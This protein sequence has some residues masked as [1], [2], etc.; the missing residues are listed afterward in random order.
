[1]PVRA[2]HPVRLKGTLVWFQQRRAHLGERRPE[3]GFR[4]FGI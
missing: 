3:C 1:M 4:M 2:L